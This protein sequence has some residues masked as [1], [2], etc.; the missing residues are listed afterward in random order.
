[1]SSFAIMLLSIEKFLA[2][3]TKE[4]YCEKN[5]EFILEGLDKLDK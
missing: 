1:M 5:I 3:E 4:W 2:H